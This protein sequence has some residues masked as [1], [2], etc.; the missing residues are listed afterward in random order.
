MSDCPV[1]SKQYQFVLSAVLQKADIQLLCAVPCA[2][3]AITP[4]TFNDEPDVLERFNL[5]FHVTKPKALGIIF[6]QIMCTLYKVSR[7]RNWWQFL[8]QFIGRAS[9]TSKL[10]DKVMGERELVES[11]RCNL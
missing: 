7:S 4:Q 1:I 8:A 6:D 3:I 10:V 5:H 9:H 2:E 11:N